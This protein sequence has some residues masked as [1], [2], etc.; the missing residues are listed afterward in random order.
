MTGALYDDIKF[1]SASFFSAD[2]LI[3]AENKK[4][5]DESMGRM[6]A[7]FASQSKERARQQK[8]TDK[9]L[10]R[11]LL[12]RRKETLTKTSISSTDNGVAEPLSVKSD[13]QN[14]D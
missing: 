1:W 5:G 3:F 4:T 13:L 11:M 12:A 2:A 8:Q 10:K 9:A 6:L 7:N 14:P